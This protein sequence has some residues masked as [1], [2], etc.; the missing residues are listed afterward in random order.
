MTTPTMRA[1]VCRK[2]GPPEVLILEQVQR[3]VPKA[4]EMLIRVHATAV[5]S[6]D[7]RLRKPDPWAVRLFLGFFAPRKKIMG[8][9]FSGVVESVGANVQK[10]K[11]GDRVFGSTLMRFGA[12]AEFMCLPEKAH[13]AR[14]PDKLSFTDAAAIPFGAMTA[15][16]YLEKAK[17]T[18]GQRVL[19]L[20]AS[21]A[22]GTAAVQLAKA[23]GAEVTA[24]CSGTNANLV[25]ALGANHTLDYTKP[26]FSLGDKSYDVIYETVSSRPLE[27]KLAAVK[28]GGALALSD[29]GFGEMLRAPFAGR[30]RQVRVVIGVTKESAELM[31]KI[32]AAVAAGQLKAVIDRTYPLEQM[33]EAHRYVEGRHKKGNVV[34]TV[35]ES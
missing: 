1:I 26:D 24:V 23:W 21:G 35:A 7:W 17:I 5:N 28:T 16:H 2:Y 33:A 12:Y 11:A 30:K 10:F 22:V 20:G 13:I 15:W 29:A 31:E 18:P 9:V 3:P 25:K 4:D 19:I 32:S 6:A 27:Q 8:G 34:I 14:M